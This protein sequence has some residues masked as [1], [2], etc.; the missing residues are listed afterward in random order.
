VGDTYDSKQIQ[1]FVEKVRTDL[2]GGFISDV[3][4]VGVL[5]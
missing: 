4:I 3:E 1:G 2:A 5:L